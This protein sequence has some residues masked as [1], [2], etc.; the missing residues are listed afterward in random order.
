MAFE[1]YSTTADIISKIGKQLYDKLTEQTDDADP[2]PD[3]R[4]EQAITDADA[5]INSYIREVV[6]TIPMT[7]VPDLIKQYSRDLAICELYKNQPQYIP[8]Q[9][10]DEKQNIIRSLRD[11]S[12]GA[13][14]L[15]TGPE[16]DDQIAKIAYGNGGKKIIRERPL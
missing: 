4:A 10:K 2:E 13:A 14:S 3:V 1:A 11:I 5:I 15:D 12:N 7:T 6:V 16:E 9:W 8:E